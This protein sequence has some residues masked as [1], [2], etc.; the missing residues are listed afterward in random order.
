[1]MRPDYTRFVVIRVIF[2]KKP[3]SELTQILID[4][5]IFNEYVHLHCLQILYE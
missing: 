3:A 5:C 2:V 4:E 1:M